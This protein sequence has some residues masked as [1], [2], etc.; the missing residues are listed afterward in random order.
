MFSYYHL[1]IIAS[2]LFSTK[3]NWVLDQIRANSA[4]ASV[5]I[6]FQKNIKSKHI[7]NKSARYKTYLELNKGTNP[8]NFNTGNTV[9]DHSLLP[10]SL[11]LPPLF[12]KLYFQ[13]PHCYQF[14]HL[15][16][17]YSDPS[18][19]FLA[20]FPMKQEKTFFH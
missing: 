3:R 4:D 5:V 2:I 9:T 19:F 13:F 7:F 17:V 12:E 16:L 11:H 15:P 18:V 6:I 1:Y 14:L 10:A 20:A 8:N